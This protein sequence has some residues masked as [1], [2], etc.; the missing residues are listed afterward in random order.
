MTVTVSDHAKIR[1]LQRNHKIDIRKLKTEMSAQGWRSL[2]DSAVLDFIEDTTG[3]T[4]ELIDSEILQVNKLSEAIEKGAV[5]F[6]SN[7]RHFVISQDKN[8]VT[9]T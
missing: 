4:R 8:I 5:G 2:C 9:I 1:W 3:L 6:T 7:G